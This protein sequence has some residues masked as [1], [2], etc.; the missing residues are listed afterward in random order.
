V[1]TADLAVT[2]APRPGAR[3]AFDDGLDLQLGTP[4]DAGTTCDS[5][6]SHFAQD[7][8]ALTLTD[9]VSRTPSHDH[10]GS[11]DRAGRYLLSVHRASTAGTDQA[12][13]PIE[14]SY[15]AEAPLPARTVPAG[16]R[17]DYGTPPPPV[18]GTPR[19]VSGGSDFNTAPA[20]G[21]GVWR[22][23]L[24]PAQVRYYGVR[25]GWGQQLTY[26]AQFAN[27]PVPEGSTADSFVATATY[28]PG[29][30]PVRDAS[31]Q[32][33]D[34]LYDGSP[35]SIGLGTVP[36]S[37]TNR[38]VTD[39]AA[40][41]VHSPGT[42]WITLGLG[43]GAARLGGPHTAVGVVLRIRVSGRE[44]AGPQD[45]A[46]PPARTSDAPS[47]VNDQPAQAGSAPG[48]GGAGPITGADLLAAGGGGAVALAG[49]GTVA[50]VHRG[51]GRGAGAAGATG[52]TRGGV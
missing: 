20:L 37:W 45:Q 28:A 29:R 39:D 19:D 38:W 17:T 52:A 40:Q 33:G 48:R 11:C 44:L 36:V 8:G 6:S 18:T 51:R 25:L 5:Q 26:T 31:G 47:R 23:R 15:T 1:S 35:V 7:E 32:S 46:P 12:R 30:L 43:P 21:T 4:G 41:N 27:S 9:A 42:Y 3:V 22:D 10:T 50:R 2:A 14:V 24:F 49:L 13:W 16:A 34:R